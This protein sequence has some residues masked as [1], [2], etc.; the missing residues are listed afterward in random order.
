MK[1]IKKVL[2]VLLLVI[3][4]LSIM[5]MVV[6]RSHDST[7][8]KDNSVVVD[9]NKIADSTNV[10][11]EDADDTLD[12]DV[13]DTLDDDVNDDSS[14]EDVKRTVRK[15]VDSARE[16]VQR[17]KEGVESA[18]ERVKMAQERYADAKSKYSDAREKYSLHK[19]RLVELKN[20]VRDCDEDCISKKTD[21][22][23]GVLN[24]LVKTS[25]LIEKSL[26]KLINRLD[27]A[28]ISDE[29]KVSALATL[30]ELQLKVTEQ[31]E[32]VL[33]LSETASNDEVRE[34]IADLKQIWKEVRNTQKRVITTLT[35]AKLENLVEKHKEYDNGMSLRIDQLREQGV[36]VARLE[37]LQRLFQE[38]VKVLEADYLVA[39]DLW[40]NAKQ[41]REDFTKWHEAQSKVRE[42][43]I[44]S[45]KLLRQFLSVYRDLKPLG[46][47]E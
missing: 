5:Q 45:K 22:K 18:K 23:K 7:A 21:L 38:H 46:E 32:K 17:A 10:D 35:N 19:D 15:N 6:A 41:G 40:A 43:L 37:G 14:M 11:K 2:T 12:D 44:E 9:R 33:A 34:A 20:K 27:H 3:F 25:E 29:E 16:N 31:K 26:E 24:H 39:K 28:P 4:V 30:N 1:I 42:D 8:E 36:D 47:S 13:S